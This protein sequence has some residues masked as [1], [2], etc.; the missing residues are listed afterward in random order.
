VKVHKK[1]KVI[2]KINFFTK[3]R[4]SRF[5]KGK[6]SIIFLDEKIKKNLQIKKDKNNQ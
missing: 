4:L 6:K 3:I 5:Q 2:K 1:A